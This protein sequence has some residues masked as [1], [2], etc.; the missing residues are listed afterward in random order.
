[1]ADTWHTGRH[2]PFSVLWQTLP[3]ITG[4]FPVRSRCGLRDLLKT[5][6]WTA[7]TNVLVLTS[8]IKCICHHW[9]GLRTSDPTYPC[10]SLA[11]EERSHTHMHIFIGLSVSQNVVC[12]SLASESPCALIKMWIPETYS[13]AIKSEYS[14][15]NS[16]KY[17]VG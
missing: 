5:V 15:N 16:F 1:M 11:H 10:I 8:E 7:P 6:L 4:L 12:R 2:A 14:Q 3:S 13:R 17:S 9:K